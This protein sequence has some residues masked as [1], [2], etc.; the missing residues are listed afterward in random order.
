MCIRDSLPRWC[1][2]FLGV[3]WILYAERDAPTPKSNA[4]PEGSGL[5]F[6]WKVPR[7]RAHTE[8]SG[9]QI[10]EYMPIVQP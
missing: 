4:H 8:C 2:G 1:L 7:G 6:L 9:G 3:R 10:S 5:V